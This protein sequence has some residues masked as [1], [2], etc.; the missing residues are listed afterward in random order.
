MAT[1]GYAGTLLTVDLSDGTITRRPTADDSGRFIGGRGL[2]AKLFWD[3][4]PV[5]AGAFDPD[6]ALI[7]VT[8]PMA[9]FAGFAGY[10]WQ[11]CGKAPAGDK[12]EFSFANLGGKW[13]GAL[14]AAG[15]D[16]LVVR[17]RSP[18]PVYLWIGED[19]V[20]VRDARRLW[21]QTTFGA[22]DQLQSRY[23]PSVSVL[24]VG[25]AAENRV[26]FATMLTD[27]GASG[28]GG[29]GGVMGSKR[30]KAVVVSGNRK[31]AAAHPERLR[32]LRARVKGMRKVRFLTDTSWKIPGVTRDSICYGCG[33]GCSRQ[34]YRDAGGKQFKS[35]CQ[36]VS[37]YVGPSRARHGQWHAVQLEAARLCDA[38][39][40]DT[41]VMQALIEWLALCHQEG[42]IDERRAGVPFGE[43]GN[44]AFIQALTRRIALREGFG[45]ALARGPI[46]AAQA[47]GGRAE[48][49]V[50]DFVANRNGEKKDYDPRLIPVSALLFATEPRRP[51]QQLHE[52][53]N[54]LKMWL[55][56][57]WKKPGAF[58]DTDDLLRAARLFWG[59]ESA[60]D[61][62]SW[63]GKALAA[64]KIQDRAYV[65]ESMILCDFNWPMIWTDYPGG[66][67]GDP[68]LESQ[69]YSAVTGIALDEAGLDAIGERIFNLQ[70]AILLRQGRAGRGDDGL[71]DALHRE[72]LKKGE[73]F[74]DPD[75]LVPGRGGT[76]AS[77][78]GRI[79][80]REEFEA[81]KS[82]YYALRGWDARSGRPTRATLTALGLGDVA[83]VLAREGLLGG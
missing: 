23:G 4:V 39:G 14:K 22:I 13:G 53:S 21:G 27:D 80:D 56:W 67:V 71:L 34:S 19:R 59:S 58:F 73:I 28:S 69:V 29:L 74:F 5:D 40:L 9:G 54:L 64:K 44:A 3:L 55:N 12:E 10:R 1:F 30:L 38:Y 31:V 51:I 16:G 65:K 33:L 20:E 42:A 78:A 43:L 45:D 36:A 61:F 49:L 66:H 60:A 2:A 8:G 11:V 75:C 77:N 83:D 47:L 50:F 41:M 7:F 57:V 81:C 24:A 18:A 82:D 15:C 26:A 62:T 46:A 37:V 17:G 35:F 52:V 25:P 6:N 68:G 76:V 72:P 48:A 70:R 32:E 79:V 63:E